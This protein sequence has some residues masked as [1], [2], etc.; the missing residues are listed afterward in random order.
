MA[1]QNANAADAETVE[2]EQSGPLFSEY[3]KPTP[4]LWVWLADVKV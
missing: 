1:V 2:T 3:H 4:E